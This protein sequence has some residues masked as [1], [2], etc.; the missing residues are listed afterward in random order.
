MKLKI[1]LILIF[2]LTVIFSN[3][4]AADLIVDGR[5]IK[6]GGVHEYGEVKVINGGTI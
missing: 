5:T 6:I 3:S 2:F 4:F 1:I